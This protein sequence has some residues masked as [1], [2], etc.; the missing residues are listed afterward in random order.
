M[1]KLL[2]I[3]AVLVIFIIIVANLPK[4]KPEPAPKEDF[5]STAQVI[6][7]DTKEPNTWDYF[8]DSD[9]MTD[10]KIYFGSLVAEEELNLKFPY[11]GGVSVSLYIKNKGHRNSAFLK[12]SKGQFTGDYIMA[13]FDGSKA[14]SYATSESNDG[15]NTYAFIDEGS[16]F[17]SRVKRSKKTVI[18]IGLYDNGWQIVNFNTAGLVWTYK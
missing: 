6:P 1:K 11:N 3:I 18:Q 17:V 15:D 13:R 10:K 2:L 14:D 12:L 4:S 8:D 5:S 16:N 7:Q 9:K